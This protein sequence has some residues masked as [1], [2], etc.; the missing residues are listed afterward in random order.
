MAE[1]L[2]I[3]LFADG[4][5]NWLALDAGGRA[6]SAA[7]AGVPPAPAV[8]RAQRIVVLV[9][10]EQVLLLQTAR[11]PGA[12][13]QWRRALPFALEDRLASPVE[14]LHFAVAERAD[15]ASLA[16]AV[17]ASA[18]LRAWLERLARDGIR[19]DALYAETQ[20]LPC[21]PSGSVVIDG[22]RALWRADPAQAG[23]CAV[24]T[25]PDW[26]ALLAADADAAPAFEVYD[27]RDAPP[28]PIAATRYHARQRDVLG[29]F[30]AQLAEEPAINLLQGEFAPAHRQAPTQKLWRHAAWLAATAVI[31]LFV[32]YG[33]DCWRL[34]RQSAQLDA[35]AHGILQATFPGM[36]K[37]AGDPRQLMD[38]AMRGARGNASGTGLMHLLARIAPVLS[39]G[40]RSVLTGME[41]HNA[42]LELAIRAPDVPTLDLLRES[43]ATLPG[44]KVEVTAAN[45]G[46]QGID[47][48]LRIAG[49]TP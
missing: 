7:N 2:L 10:A 1:R 11:L 3:R 22:E 21:R 14:E 15:G 17:V 37:V 18:T 36:D 26:L 16:V 48:R 27:F 31:L 42:T 28:L 40:T 6:L 23:A 29:F 38:S 33:A 9:P 46:A 12:R 19:A 24:A 41:Y 39:N 34:S 5:S 47:G 44:L 32:Y 30:A 45:S 4:E 8:A 20:L 43:L 25:W 49:A 13:A 35:A